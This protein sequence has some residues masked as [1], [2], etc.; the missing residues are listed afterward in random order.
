MKVLFATDGSPRD[1]VARRFVAGARWPIGTQIELFGVAVPVAL[2]VSGE[3]TDRNTR[4]FEH[5]LARR[6]AHADAQRRREEHG[7]HGRRN[8]RDPDDGRQPHDDVPAASG[9]VSTCRS[10]RAGRS[11]PVKPWRFRNAIAPTR[12]MTAQCRKCV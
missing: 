4:D 10:S 7:E 1:D 5:E 8:D 11:T 6:R 12:T 3:L 9:Q 2:A